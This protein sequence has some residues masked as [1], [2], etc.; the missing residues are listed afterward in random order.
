MDVTFPVT[1]LEDF[2]KLLKSTELALEEAITSPAV[3]LVAVPSKAGGCVMRLRRV[4][5]GAYVD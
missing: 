5:N 4:D 3:E 2:D 1:S